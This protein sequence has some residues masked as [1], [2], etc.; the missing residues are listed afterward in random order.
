M[1]EEKRW[2]RAGR[3]EGRGNF[4]Q[5]ILYGSSVFKRERRGRK[6]EKERERERDRETE[7]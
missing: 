1:E 6:W 3:I 5:D 7:K 2:Q 4:G